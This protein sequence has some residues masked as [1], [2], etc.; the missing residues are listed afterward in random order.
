M[1]P[2]DPMTDLLAVGTRN[3]LFLA[4][5]DD[6]RRTWSVDGPHLLAQ[7]VG[8]LV[9]PVGADRHA[10]RGPRRDLAGDRAGRPPLPGGDRRRARP[11]LA[12]ALRH[13]RASRRRVGRLR[14]PLAVAQRRR[15]R[16]LL[17]G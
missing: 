6:G 16:E 15:G 4:R 7:A 11:G 5:S 10:L 9:R 14:A 17:A 3:G 8:D 1:T 12:A 13:P 2:E